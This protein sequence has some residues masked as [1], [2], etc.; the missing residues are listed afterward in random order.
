FPLITF[1]TN[2][3][4]VT[5]GSASILDAIKFN[6]ITESADLPFR[7][8]ESKPHL[9][10]EAHH[11]E[12]FDFDMD[13]DIDIYAGFY[14]SESGS[15][16]HALWSNN[17]GVFTDITAESGLS[18][19]GMEND[20][21]SADFDNDGYPDLYIIK[22]EG[23]ILYRNN[24]KGKFENVTTAAFG[25]NKLTKN[26]ISGLFVDADHDGDLDIFECTSGKNLFFRNNA[27]GTFTEQAGKM[28]LSGEEIKSSHACFG[29]FDEDGDIDL[30]VTNEEAPAAMFSNQRQSLFRDIAA[31]S[32]MENTNGATALAAGDYNN[33]GFIDIFISTSKG[34]NLIFRNKGNGTFETPADL[35]VPF[36][37]ASGTMITAARFL[38]FDNDGAS[39]L[40]LAGKVNGADQRGLFLFHNNGKGSFT[41]VSGILSENIR[42]VSGVTLFD[43][44]GDGDIDIALTRQEGGIALLRNDGGN[45]NHYVRINLVGLRAGSSKN[46]HFGIGAK[47]ELRAGDLY[48][49]KVVTEPDIYFGIGDK[50]AADVIRITWTNGV[51]QNIFYPAADQALIEAQTLKGSCPFL[52]TWNGSEYVFVKD[53]LWRSG[54]GMPL[55][56]MGGNTAYAFADASDDYLR[57]PG[58]NLKPLNGR[59]S[60]QVT[61]E[62]WETIY[63]DRLELVA[64]DHP[65]STD[66]Y[67]EE[68]FAPPPFPG[69]KI[70]TVG[71]KFSP[72]S[73]VDNYGNNIL[74]AVISKDHKYHAGGETGKYQGLTE[75]SG[76]IIDAGAAAANNNAFMFLTGWIFPTDASINIALSQSAGTKVVPPYVQVMN[77]EG[78]WVTVIESLGFPMGKDK[79]VT[80][81]L[82][83]KFLCDDHR[84]RIVTNMEIHWDQIFFSD[85]LSSAPV[86]KTIMN[87]V[88]ADLHYRGFSESFRNGGNSGPHWFDYSRVTTK[89]KWRDLAGNYTKYGDVR[90]LLIA[91][92]NKYIISN[93]GD[94]V[95]VEFDEEDIPALKKGWNRDFLIRSVGWVK[96]GDI[97]TA[98]GNTVLPLPFHGMKSYPPSADD[99]YPDSEDLKRYNDEYNTR[100]VNSD[101]YIDALKLNDVVSHKPEA[102]VSFRDVTEDAGIDFRYTFGDNSY[103]NILESSGAGITIFDYNNDNQMDIYLLNG[104]WL[105][106][107]SDKDG[108]KNRNA[109]DRLYRNNGDGTFTDVTKES[110]LTD[111]HWSMAATAVDYDR[112]GDQDIYLLNYGPNIFFR[113]NGDGTFTDITNQLGLAGPD[114]LNGFPKW[115][116]EGAPIDYNKDGR[117]DL[118]VGNFLAYDPQYNSPVTPGLMPHPSEY[119]GQ[120]SILY[121]QLPDGTFTDVTKKAGLFYPDSKCMGIS[122]FDYDEDGDADIFQANDHHLNYL[123]RNNNGVFTETA[124]S[125]GVAVNSKGI[126]SGSMQGTL[127]DI[128]GDG[129]TDLLVT[130]LEFGALYRNLGKGIFKDE[131]WSSGI[132]WALTG[133]G[134]WGAA[135]FDYDNDG[136]PDLVSANGTAE[137]LV[138]QYP[139]LMENDGKG[140][141]TDV[142]KEKGN[143]FN[144][145]RSGR[146]LAVLD[147]DNDGDMDIII[148]HVDKPGTPALL[149]NEGGNENHWIGITLKGNDPGSS[150]AAKVNV[151][152]GGKKQV[153]VNQFATSYLS[154]NDPRI[155]A[156][157][158]ASKTIDILE[159][160]WTG[161]KKEIYRNVPADRYITITEGKGIRQTKTINPH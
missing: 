134:G 119:R 159:V 79:T 4:P 140:H 142:G 2:R 121:E 141:F 17:S 47:V 63:L 154:S 122:V 34:Q 60:L 8:A 83:G 123:F 93:A 77:N 39:D 55:G 32:G 3:S 116:I 13:G 82:R 16:R 155:H 124:R 70:F 59:Y 24:R 53:I 22:P 76:L 126:G 136:D 89:A 12:S 68:Q 69:L 148:S 21:V 56:I 9:M 102:S 80:A 108:K 150:V 160:A 112:D 45:M 94:E 113:N 40:L 7:K 105:E 139:L 67:V 14:D 147:Y 48:Q 103:R 153:F 10:K 41:D 143:Y 152:A 75:M 125:C 118:M 144:V 28:G 73:A 78:K 46:N 18:H 20:A 99:K 42:G 146:G 130:D 101:S 85:G 52:Y 106:G 57:V 138:L 95:T 132:A 137:E 5:T 88:S 58:E 50:T 115:S 97:N 98:F 109:S 91:S 129:L 25:K 161:G 86:L 38:D 90:P 66:I 111:N 114:S 36:K 87:P 72:A 104:T 117:I 61:S 27:D 81:D 30:F 23:D 33:D 100:S 51:P 145:R 110:G 92:D 128:D 29:D 157:L 64:V 15:F 131:T 26:G 135:L 37:V 74:P 11:I 44:N 84:I 156:G 35:D 127:G 71:K 96:D 31:G 151:T 19:K 65:D 49:A 149:K 62:L 107:I 1:D 158:G 120:E 43:Y 133:K 54:L 6:D